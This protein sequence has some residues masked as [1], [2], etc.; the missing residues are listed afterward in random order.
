MLREL[1]T[2]VGEWRLFSPLTRLL[3]SGNGRLVVKGKPLLLLPSLL[4]PGAEGFQRWVIRHMVRLT[5]PSDS[6][7]SYLNEEV[8]R[9][10]EEIKIDKAPDARDDATWYVLLFVL[11][12]YSLWVSSCPALERLERDFPSVDKQR[13][14]YYRSFF[15][16]WRFLHHLMRDEPRERVP[17]YLPYA[18]FIMEYS[19]LQESIAEAEYWR[20][21]RLETLEAKLD[22]VAAYL[23]YNQT[24]RVVE[25][26]ETVE[27][28]M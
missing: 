2:A 11:R 10:L 25:A 12:F 16:H 7:T 15:K 22:T 4:Q 13:Q 18:V 1:G 24:R 5:R 28:E 17:G 21:L 23:G 19:Q 20:D 3:E 6:V 9:L 14:K 27:V 8:L 26:L